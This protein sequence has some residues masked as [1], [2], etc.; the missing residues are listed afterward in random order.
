MKEINIEKKIISKRLTDYVFFVGSL[1]INSNYFIEKIEKGII[2]KDAL[3]FA[4]NV[5]GHQ[6]SFDFFVKD[7]NF[8]DF[9]LKIIDYL[10][11][12]DYKFDAYELRE[13]WGIKLGLSHY[14]K[15]HTHKGS[16]LS[17]SLYLNDHDQELIFPEINESVK[18]KKG[19]FI[20]FS[21]NLQHYTK[22]NL[23]NKN[24]YA[25]PFNFFAKSILSV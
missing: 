23:I 7:I 10:D 22:R 13:A 11:Q 19:R 12:L 6:T 5:K 4:T 25:I 21:S 24:K 1:N 20:I 17:G 15:N 14:T 2:E 8:L 9:L 16:L 18:P 3:N